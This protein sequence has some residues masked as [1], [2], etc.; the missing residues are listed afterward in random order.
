MSAKFDLTWDQKNRRW[1][2]VFRGK[3][4]TISCRSL[5]VPEN[6][7]DSYQAANAWWL[8]KEAEIEGTRPPHPHH[9]VITELEERLSWARRHGAVED[10]ARVV[11]QI[12]VVEGMT[13]SAPDEVEEVLLDSKIVRGNIELARQFGI[14]VPGNLP[15]IVRD[16]IFGDRRQWEDRATQD[17]DLPDVPVERTVAA[18]VK[19]H[20][21]LERARVEGGIVSVGEF[22]IVT[23]SLHDFQNWIG[24]ENLI[25]LIDADRIESWWTHLVGTSLSVETKK[26]KLRHVKSFVHWIVEKGLITQPTNLHSRRHRFGG[27]ARAVRT[28]PTSEVKLL[29]ESASGQ[30]RLHI[31]LM[32]N[33]G[34]T[35]VDISDLKPKEVDWER[36]RIKR[37]RSKT[38]DHS[39][40]PVVDYPLWPETI[41][42]L[43]LYGRRDGERALLTE[44]GRP[45]VRDSL[46][47]NGKRSKVDNIKSNFA[48]VK[49]RKELK[50]SMKLLRKTSASLLETMPE[51]ARYATL[52]LGHAP[53]SIADR[54]YIAPSQV[55]FDE[56]VLWLG[57]MYSLLDTSLGE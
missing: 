12:Y 48:H 37:K 17:L 43:R 29:I 47:P 45:W 56:A 22:E 44:S 33:C 11:G 27:S 25:D 38:E 20:L 51:F 16:L 52:F 15:A 9:E 40:V 28:I 24:G 30:L 36:G 55:N 49:R 23:R 10:V 31:L 4:Y 41:R 3:V 57:G 46:L 39:N 8:K 5:N 2:K 7:K 42:L 26:K 14:V 32:I 13:E 18:Q 1:R 6:K 50:Y 34:M 54:H 53:R 35:Q 21:D 19:R